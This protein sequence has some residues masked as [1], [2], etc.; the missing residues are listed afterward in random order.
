[1]LNE[2]NNAYSLGPWSIKLSEDGIVTSNKFSESKTKWEG[3]EK[4]IEG[5]EHI[6]IYVGTHECP[7]WNLDG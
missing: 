1:M 6:F 7:S 3:I 4:I 5:E 2:G